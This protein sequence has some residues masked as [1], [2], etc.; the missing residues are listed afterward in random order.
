MLE[1]MIMNRIFRH[2]MK[3]HGYFI[4]FCAIFFTSTIIVSSFI[5]RDFIDE[6]IFVEEEFEPVQKF[7]VFI[8]LESILWMT[9]AVL[10]VAGL[11]KESKYYIIPFLA[12]FVADGVLV[13]VQ[14][15]INLCTGRLSELAT[16][17]TR[18]L[19]VMILANLYVVVSLVVLYRMFSKEPLPTTHNNFVRFDNEQDVEAAV[20]GSIIGVPSAP[21]SPIISNGATLTSNGIASPTGVGTQHAT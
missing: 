14:D 16:I 19:V 12:L 21:P 8:Q 4:S 6:P 3:F 15:T 1:S 2:F 18:Q 7:P 5:G 13:I 11:Y 9:A 20:S 17:E 10:L